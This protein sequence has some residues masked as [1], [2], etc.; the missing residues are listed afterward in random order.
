MFN[1]FLDTFE[2]HNVLYRR[3]CGYF[4]GNF[5]KKIGLLFI[6]TSGHTAGRHKKC[7]VNIFNVTPELTRLWEDAKAVVVAVVMVRLLDLLPASPGFDSR[8]LFL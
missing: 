3:C 6:P 5:C 7:V 4:W 1:N 2:K 8:Q